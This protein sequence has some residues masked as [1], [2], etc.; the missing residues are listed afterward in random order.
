MAPLAVEVPGDRL[1]LC[2]FCDFSSGHWSS[3][4]RHYMNIHSK[5]VH[6]CKDCCF[7][8]GLRWELSQ[9]WTHFQLVTV[10]T[11]QTTALRCRLLLSCDN[12][13][14]IRVIHVQFK[15]SSEGFG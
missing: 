9:E 3:V 10:Q 15:R 8:T 14:W 6:R 11:R 4:R 5:K 7:F 2:E 13:V 1:L 12:K